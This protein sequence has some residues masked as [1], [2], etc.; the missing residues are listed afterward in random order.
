MVIWKRFAGLIWAAIVVVALQFVPTA[1]R[2]H[3]G[4]DHHPSRQHVSQQHQAQPSSAAT[5]QAVGVHQGDDAI[6]AARPA[7]EW[8]APPSVEGVVPASAACVGGC[9]SGMGCC[10]AAAIA[11]AGPPLPQ[12]DGSAEIVAFQGARPGGTGP[13]G[14]KRPPRTLA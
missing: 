4:H 10:A 5:K 3:S 14:L 8:K 13:D 2:A 6:D 11:A 9:C 7:V 12:H 1:A